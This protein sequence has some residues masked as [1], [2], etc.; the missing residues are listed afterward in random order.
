MSSLLF[1]LSTAIARPGSRWPSRASRPRRLE[2]RLTIIS[3]AIH[4]VVAFLVW[5]SHRGSC[6]AGCG[7]KGLRQERAQVMG[8]DVCRVDDC[9]SMA[10]NGW[11]MTII[12]VTASDLLGP[13]STGAGH[14][15]QLGIQAHSAQ[16]PG[17]CAQTA[18]PESACVPGECHPFRQSS[19]ARGRSECESAGI[20]SCLAE[21]NPSLPLCILGLGRGRA[22]AACRTCVDIAWLGGGR[23]SLGGSR[24]REGRL[25]ARAN[26]AERSEIPR[27][28]SLSTSSW[29]AIECVCVCVCRGVDPWIEDLDGE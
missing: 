4:V 13:Q 22:W 2:S 25:T 17:D 10:G 7:V 21:C 1:W 19:W 26:W 8:K 11:S 6:I 15:G 14:P 18:G 29:G 5:V 16:E 23:R 27:A 9:R 24:W 28:L 12:A 20:D 3:S